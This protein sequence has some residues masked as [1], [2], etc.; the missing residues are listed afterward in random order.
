MQMELTTLAMDFETIQGV[1]Q[2]LHKRLKVVEVKL[3]QQEE[4]I[5]V[6]D[7]IIAKQKEM[8][9]QYHNSVQQHDLYSE[10]Q[11]SLPYIVTACIVL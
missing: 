7:N 11:I 2:G 9:S 6:R 8:L 5:S 3:K 10:V 4:Q 1:V